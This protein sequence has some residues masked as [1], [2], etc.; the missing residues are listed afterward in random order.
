MNTGT[1]GKDADD[2]GL[3][4]S[5]FS[6]GWIGKASYPI[7]HY[8]KP[9]LWLFVAIT[10]ALGWSATRL[11]VSAGFSKMIPLKHEYMLTFQEYADTFGG[12]NK[13]LVSL[14]AKKGDIY[15]KEFIETLRKV[16]EEIFYI[17][18]VERSSVT[19]LV[20]ANVRYTEVVEDGFKGDVL[21]PSNFNGAP[22][23]LALVRGNTAKSD[24]IGRIVAS[25]HTSAMVVATLQELDP[26]TGKPLDLRAIGHKL[27]DIRAKYETGDYTVNIIGF[28]KSIADIADGA[29]GV[30][31]FFAVAFVITC[32]LLYWYSGSLM[33]ASYAI[34][35]AVVPV[36]WLLG[37]LPLLGLALDPMSILVPFLIFSIAVSHAVQMTNGWKLETLAG[38]DGVTA[39]RLCFE[40]LFIP[41][42]IAL[43]ANALGFLVIAFVQIKMVQ[44]LTITATL[45]VTVMI[46]TN[47]MLLPILLSYRQFSAKAAKKLHGR[48]TMGHGLWKRL[49]A[50]AERKTAIYAVTIAA[51]A[52]VAGLMIAKDLKVGDLGAGVPE[53]RPNARYNKDVEAITKDYAIGVDLLQVIAVGAKDSEGPCVERGVMDKLEE[54]DLQM[55]QT[56]GVA[57]VRSLVGFVKQVTQ[58]YAETFIKWRMLPEDKAQIAQG[59]GAATRLGNEFMS[60]GCKAMAISIFTSDHQATTI[61]NIVAKIKEFKAAGGD[62]D[63]VQFKLASG[64][65][66]VMAATNEVVHASDKWV[67][68]ALFA[69][70]SLLCLIMFRSWRVTLCIILPLA[71][72]TLLCNAVMAL[73]GIGVKVNTLPVVAL[74]VGVG[75][76]YGIY[77]FESMTHALKEHPEITLREAFV[78]ALKQRGTASV[79]TAVTMTISVAT[80]SMSALKFQADMGIL[81]AFMFLVNMLGAILL[82][83]ALAACLYADR[84]NRVNAGGG[85]AARAGKGV[86]AKA[87]KAATATVLV[88]ILAGA[89][90]LPSG[91]EAA[92]TAAE[93]DRLG[94]DLT[95]VG[96]ER[97][98]NKDG[99]IPEWTG[100]LTSPPAG[101]TPEGGYTDPF[102]AD[103]P[104]FTVSA[105]NLAQYQDK[106]TPGM[107]VLLKA[108]PNSLRMNV[109]PTRRTAAYPKQVTDLVARYAPTAVLDGGAIRNFGDSSVPFPIPK[110]GEEALWNHLVRYQGGAFDI[111]LDRTVVLPGEEASTA[112]IGAR[113]IWDTNLEPRPREREIVG[114]LRLLAPAIYAGT[115][116]VNLEPIGFRRTERD[117]FIFNVSQKR[118]RREDHAEYDSEALAVGGLRVLDQYDGFNG[119]PDRFDWKLLGKK[120]I[121]VPYNAYRLGDKSLKASQVLG[122]NSVNPDLVRY[123]LHRVWVVEGTVKTG[124]RHVYPKRTFYL[125][126]D[127]WAILYEDAYDT[128][129]N[130]WRVA[131]HPPMQVYDVPTPFYRAHVYHDLTNGGYLV[132]GL[133][134]ESKVPWRFNFKGKLADWTP[135]A[136]M[137][138]AGK[139]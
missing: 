76:D 42:A 38:H 100:G 40:K 99:S 74:G 83:P 59:V 29:A 125:D 11:Q 7:F 128:R 90:L 10:V 86:T 109:Y 96:A 80:W 49:G 103:K 13:I 30:L 56:E 60:S 92:L 54:F 47:K 104:L 98:A 122:K 6:K 110:N 37:L 137:E 35:C 33:L 78:D 18:G 5:D 124:F 48:E 51:V 89:V 39:S 97:G 57:S 135:E 3:Q 27:E 61:D 43:L 65:V 58:N 102:A 63:R 108:H 1:S 112:K 93:V 134:N 71:L 25:D 20:T 130:L 111:R 62:D 84:D 88:A 67:N 45:G 119:T 12:A 70:V 126:E 138:A 107:A 14:K 36:I 79:F 22:E 131:M 133:D 87:A 106:L 31:V 23:Q 69:S 85:K 8:R 77:L 16:T 41:G 9:L 46:I 4:R 81:L 73:L 115:V 117:S 44:E 101:W 50:L 17:P 118:L 53:L 139:R 105:A 26:E 24:W 55:K 94:K 121:Y 68:L 95:P 123:E 15:T 75:V 52:T 32:I 116:R 2:K 136:I 127:S 113:V 19:S 132:E 34:I 21:V 91:A 28:A 66:G 114:I 64:N 72:V 82:L 120:E 129:G